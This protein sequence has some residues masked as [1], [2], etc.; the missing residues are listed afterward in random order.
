MQAFIS[1]P[2]GVRDSG[3][4]FDLEFGMSRKHLWLIFLPQFV[5]SESSVIQ[6]FL[7][8][9]V[10]YSCFYH[11]R[12]LRSIHQL[13]TTLA[14]AL[15]YTRIELGYSSYIG[16]SLLP[17]KQVVNLVG[18]EGTYYYSDNDEHVCIQGS[19]QGSNTPKMNPFMLKSVKNSLKYA[20]IGWNPQRHPIMPPNNF[21]MTTSLMMSEY[22]SND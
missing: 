7:L 19:F 10:F 15:I 22:L 21:V 16:L 12:Q 4:P 8:T 11:L 20:Q 3:G 9:Y 6:F 5:I 18:C 14:C 13:L 17:F 1:C 2:V